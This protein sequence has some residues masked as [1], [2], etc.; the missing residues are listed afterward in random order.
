MPHDQLFKELLHAFFGEFLELF[1][2]VALYLA[3]GSGGLVDERYEEHLFGKRVLAFRYACVGLPDLP[4]DEYLELRNPLAAGLSALMRQGRIDRLGRKLAIIQ[5]SLGSSIDE[6][7]KALLVNLAETYLPL[8]P[9]EDHEPRRELGQQEFEEVR[10]MLIVYEERGIL[11]GKRDALLR[12]MRH[13]FGAV[14]D[15][16]V[17]RG[18]QSTRRATST[19][20]SSAS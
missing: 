3:P 16:V 17:T 5:Q 19:R 6:A 20:S 11:K 2:P 10:E 9:S 14:P 18:K 4:A 1:F 7:R 12:L 13:K 15:D 8:S